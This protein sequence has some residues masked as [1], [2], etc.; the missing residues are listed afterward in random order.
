MDITSVIVD[1]DDFDT[2]EF[3]DFKDEVDSDSISDAT[4]ITNVKTDYSEVEAFD[5]NYYSYTTY[6]QLQ[7][8]QEHDDYSQSTYIYGRNYYENTYYYEAG[9]KTFLHSELKFEHIDTSYHSDYSQ[10]VTYSENTTTYYYRMYTQYGRRTVYTEQGFNREE[11]VPTQPEYYILDNGSEIKK[12]TIIGLHSLD[13]NIKG[14]GTQDTAARTVYYNLRIRK[15]RDTDG[16]NNVSSWI[17]LINNK[18]TD[19]YE[20]DTIDPLNYGWTGKTSEGYY[21]IEAYAYN[22]T[23]N[24]GGVSQSYVSTTKKITVLIK[25]NETPDITVINDTEWLDFNFGLQAAMHDTERVIKMYT[26]GLY[27]DTSNDEGLFVKFLVVDDS[28]A[29]STKM[30]LESS[31]GSKYAINE[32]TGVITSQN[33]NVDGDTEYYCTAFIPLSQLSR[34][35]SVSDVR[36]VIEV[37]DYNDIN[38]T[39]PAGSHVYVRQVSDLDTSQLVIN[40]DM[41]NPSISSMAS[42]TNFNTAKTSLMSVSDNLSGV[43]WYDFIVSKRNVSTTFALSNWFLTESEINNALTNYGYRS[44]NFNSVYYG[45]QTSAT[46][47]SDIVYGYYYRYSPHLGNASRNYTYTETDPQYIYIRV[48]DYAGNERVYKSGVNLLDKTTIDTSYTRNA[49]VSNYVKSLIGTYNVPSTEDITISIDSITKDHHGNTIAGYISDSLG[50]EVVN[51]QGYF[52][53]KTSTKYT[54]YEESDIGG[55]TKTWNRDINVGTRADGNYTFRVVLTKKTGLTKTIDIPVTVNTP[56]NLTLTGVPL[57]ESGKDATFKIETT[58]YAT[59]AEINLFEGTAYETGW[60]PMTVSG[61]P[62]SDQ[63]EW[64]LSYSVPNNVPG[65]SYDYDIRVTSDNGEEATLSGDL[66]YASI[67]SEIQHTD[68]WDENRIDYNQKHTGTDELPRPY[69]WFFGGE[70]FMLKTYITNIS[71]AT[72]DNVTVEII[73]DGY[74][75]TLSKVNGTLWDG[76][77]WNPDMIKDWNKG[78]DQNKTFR[79][80]VNYTIDSTG[81]TGQST[82]EY[83]IRVNSDED[84]WNTHGIK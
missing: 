13:R 73:E 29:I 78:Y 4:L 51:V 18:T 22:T 36:I 56:F 1:L 65:D 38:K 67:N 11:W 34:L 25:Q 59:Y 3:D 74:N 42:D 80:T 58:K 31:S 46:Y 28:T 39:D 76:E 9:R 49:D 66:V 72:I 55:H 40:T 61:N 50:Y 30:W 20:L 77:I 32:A 70:R 82:E 27:A 62:S 35:G 19:I 16:S 23:H 6:Q 64:Q 68:Q 7:T 52:T 47:G 44:S 8:S 71:G 21:E 81:D 45:K 12:T 48:I 84:F 79:F 10:M 43:Y 57:V 75:V 60:I 41:S 53:D 54:I 2:N 33:T 63:K 37:I 15:I 17:T 26:G 14:L 24:E 69:S 83:T 5:N